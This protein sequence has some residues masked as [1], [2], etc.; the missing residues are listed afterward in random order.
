MDYNA[1]KRKLQYWRKYLELTEVKRIQ[2]TKPVSATGKVFPM[3]TVFEVLGR[4]TSNE[5]KGYWVATTA[6]V[7]GYL[8]IYD[9]EC[10]V[11]EPEKKE[12]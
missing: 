2:L 9:P 10:A 7:Q 5:C 6:T 8:L 12:E 3:G 11:I 1:L 4:N